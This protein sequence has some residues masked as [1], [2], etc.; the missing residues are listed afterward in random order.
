MLALSRLAIKD[1]LSPTEYSRL[2]SA[3]QFLRELEQ[4]AAVLRRPPDPHPAH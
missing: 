4:P 3:Y 1:L 2:A